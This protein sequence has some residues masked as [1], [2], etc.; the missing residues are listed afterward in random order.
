MLLR[1]PASKADGC[2]AARDPWMCLYGMPAVG[3]RA[4][5]G[6][7]TVW[8]NSGNNETGRQP[9]SVFC[10]PDLVP[11]SPPADPRRATN[12]HASAC[13]HECVQSHRFHEIVRRTPQHFALGPA[14]LT[15]P[16]CMHELAHSVADDSVRSERECIVRELLGRGFD[17]VGD[18]R[19]T[20]RIRLPKTLFATTCARAVYRFTSS[21]ARSRTMRLR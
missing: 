6:W 13:V 16:R 5:G 7:T 18:G 4:V 15:T 2:R 3:S 19:T 14:V 12:R 21:V 8:E 9:A 11:S 1:R 10:V 20:P 17:V